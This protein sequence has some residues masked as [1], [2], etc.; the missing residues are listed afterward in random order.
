MSV[1]SERRS[2]HWPAP[3]PVRASGVIAAILVC[4]AVGP[5]AAAYGP[6]AGSIQMS[7]D[8]PRPG[9]TSGLGMRLSYRDSSNPDGKPPMI[10]ELQ[11]TLPEGT[12]LD[13]DALPRCDVP[14]EDVR[15]RGPSACPQAS[16]VGSGEIEI[17]TGFGPP[18]DPYTFDAVNF[19]ESGGIKEVV[20]DRS[21]GGVI[22]IEHL[23]VEGNVISARI[24]RG[25][26]GPPDGESTVREA[27]VNPDPGTGFVTTPPVCRGMWSYSARFTFD[28]GVVE[29]AGT[30]PCTPGRAA[31]RAA[32]ARLVV[33]PKRVRAGRRTRFRF[34][35]TVVENGRRRPLG[36]AV[37][38]FA[39]RRAVANRRG[40]ATMAA[41]LRRGFHRAAVVAPEVHGGRARVRALRRG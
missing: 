19:N 8:S 16:R 2:V 6:P 17:V 30:T 36:G 40:M 38:R 9:V 29:P 41:T 27:V 26:G 22:A 28:N 23:R 1:R 4:L 21:T 14:D 33:R 10:R 39:G 20:I 11:V 32:P 37:I 34:H 3:A 35:A 12:R 31:G 7:F 25:P 24:V 5:P 15:A 18:T 13:G